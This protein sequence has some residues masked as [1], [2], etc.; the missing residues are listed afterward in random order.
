MNTAI[1]ATFAST[2]NQMG[3]GEVPRLKWE[4]FWMQNRK[5][6]VGTLIVRGG[7]RLAQDEPKKDVYYSDHGEWRPAKRGDD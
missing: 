4:N 5:P 1:N 6:D 7:H 3:H 2:S